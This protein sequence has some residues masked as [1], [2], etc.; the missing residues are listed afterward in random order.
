MAAT[1]V[2]S[3]TSSMYSNGPPPPYSSGWSGPV[4]HSVSGLIS[5]PDSRRTSDNNKSEPPPPIQ[6]S[7]PHRQSIP[8]IHEALS[9]GPK[10][11]PYASPVSA[12]LPAAHQIPYS[13][14]QSAPIPRAYPPSDQAQYPPQLAPSQ[15][16]QP[17]PPQPIHPQPNFSRA[18]QS[19]GSFPEVSRHPS[20]TTLQAAPGPHNPYAAPRYEPVRYEPDPRPQ[21]RIPNG[22]PSH[23]PPPRQPAYNYG[24]GPHQIPPPGPH[25]PIYNQPRYQQRDPREMNDAWKGENQEPVLF[26]QG[27]KRHLDVW[28]FENNLAEVRGYI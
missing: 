3:P 23:P 18:E 5:P 14:P 7:Q 6:T 27:V 21:E 12:S 16:R 20:I 24:P 13:Q 10:P 28:D 9:N 8:S 19:T 2:V 1:V 22:Y 15:P 11:N 17:S 25:V 26:R 4:A